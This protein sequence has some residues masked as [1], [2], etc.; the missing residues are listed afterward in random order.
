MK[1]TNIFI[2]III[3]VSFAVGIYFYPKFPAR[4]ASHWN[5]QGQV[6][7]YMSKCWGLFLLPIILLAIWLLFLII[8]K[9]DPLKH[10]I[11]KFRKYFDAFI[12]LII[13]FLL[14][15]YVLTIY[16]NLGNIFNM[17]Q[18]I[19]PAIG[20]LFFY[21]GILLKHAQRN[22]FIGI[23][24]PWTLSSDNVWEKT[25]K[26]GAKLFKIAGV[27]AFLGL[28]FPGAAIWFV[29]IPAIFFALY[30]IIYSYFEYKKEKNN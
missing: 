27:I 18:A 15:L 9:I 12:V 25:H 11:E 10:N 3:L 30:T 20:L 6:D 14:Y 2:F 7:G 4:I 23:R 24:T 29:L 22:W 19:V 16:W 17:G 13:L 28:F 1:K 21:I 8:P 26:L 5:A